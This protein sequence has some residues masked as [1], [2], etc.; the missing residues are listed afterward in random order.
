[1]LALSILDGVAEA[2]KMYLLPMD[3]PPSPPSLWT[4]NGATFR[5]RYSSLFPVRD[6]LNGRQNRL[7]QHSGDNIY[8]EP[9]HITLDALVNSIFLFGIVDDLGNDISERFIVTTVVKKVPTALWGPYDPNVDQSS[10]KSTTAL[11]DTSGSTTEQMM[12]VDIGP[13]SPT[14]STDIYQVNT[15]ISCSEDVMAHTSPPPTLPPAIFV[16]TDLPN[17]LGTLQPFLSSAN[18]NM[19]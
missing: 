9:M 14:E 19:T 15:A 1:M 2:E 7:Y 12:G 11:L 17:A 8:I 16:P 13:A 10:G 4:V 6:V 3:N 5:F 18:P